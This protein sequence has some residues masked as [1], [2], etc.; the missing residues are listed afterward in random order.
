M[1]LRPRTTRL[2]ALGVL[3]ALIAIVTAVG[4]WSPI[5]G[6]QAVVVGSADFRNAPELPP[7]Q[8][9]DRIVTGDTAWYSIIYTN[10][11]PY[12]FA[13][14]FQDSPPDRGVDLSV[15]LVAPTLTT[16]DGPAAV[17]SGSG[18]T[19]PAGHT[20]AWFL[21]V[22]LAT[23]DQI[24]VEYPIVLTI[25]GVQALGTDDCSDIDACTL[26]D[27][28]AVVGVALAKATAELEQ[29][30]SQETLVAV[31][32]Q[33][34]NSRG[35]VESAS[36]LEPTAQSRLARAERQMAQLCAPDPMCVE[37]PNPG[38]RTPLIGWIFGLAALGFGA[39][40]AFKKLTTDPAPAAAPAPPRRLSSR[41]QAQA[42]KKARSKQKR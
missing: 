23:D 39:F 7:G 3:T 14:A 16:V 22:S 30:R 33:I 28:Y 19:Y 32:N 31:Q 13:V 17:V 8:Y 18:V 27:G 41:E 11:M 5:A 1:T 26:D 36:A 6:A 37:F 9:V 21:K 34:E 20:N 12:N 40:R 29:A 4:L 25:D 42:E 24:G 2:A 35:F 38:S 15:S 10:N